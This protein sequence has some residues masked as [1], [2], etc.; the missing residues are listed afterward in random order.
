MTELVDIK[1]ILTTIWRCKTNGI[2]GVAEIQ[3]W[4]MILPTRLVMMVRMMVTLTTM[5]VCCNLLYVH[6]V[7]PEQN[8]ATI[9]SMFNPFLFRHES[10][11]ERQFFK[12]L[13]FTLKSILLSARQSVVAGPQ[14]LWITGIPRRWWWWWFWCWLWWCWWWWCS[15]WFCQRRTKEAHSQAHGWSNYLHRGE[16]TSSEELGRKHSRSQIEAN[17]FFGDDDDN[18]VDEDDDDGD[19]EDNDDDNDEDEGFLT[20]VVNFLL[21][22]WMMLGSTMTRLIEGMRRRGLLWLWWQCWRRWWWRRMW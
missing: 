3:L 15:W 22:L 12:I 20:L 17:R 8:L 11:A 10:T 16:T 14:M 1:R 19:E 18:D 7:S 4:T 21:R 6:L 9:F 2:E 13:L 5:M